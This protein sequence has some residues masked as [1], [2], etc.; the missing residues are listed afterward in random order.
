MKEFIRKVKRLFNGRPV[1]W[2]NIKKGSMFLEEFE[3]ESNYCIKLNEREFMILDSVGSN[4]EGIGYKF[5]K[6]MLYD[7]LYKVNMEIQNRYVV[8]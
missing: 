3:D 4:V 7:D 1:K 6:F 8:K 5:N 2:D